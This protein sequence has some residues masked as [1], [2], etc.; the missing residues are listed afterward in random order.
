M[1]FDFSNPAQYDDRGRLVYNLLGEVTPHYKEKLQSFQFV[2]AFFM[3]LLV[4]EKT[5]SIKKRDKCHHL[6]LFS[7][8][9]HPTTYLKSPW[10]GRAE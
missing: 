10:R 5:P 9:L 8:Y 6:S 7:K 3:H 4:Q 1:L 2:K